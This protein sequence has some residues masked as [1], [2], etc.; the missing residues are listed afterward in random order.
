MPEKFERWPC[1]CDWCSEKR[2]KAEQVRKMEPLAEEW[3]GVGPVSDA[4]STEEK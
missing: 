2:R 3:R 1:N 4:T